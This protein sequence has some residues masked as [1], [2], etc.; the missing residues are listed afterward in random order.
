MDRQQQ[1]MGNEDGFVLVVALMVLAI[2][3]LIGIAGVATALIEQHIA[4]NERIR[5]TTF[6]QADGG[7]Q[8]AIRLVEEN[9]GSPGGFTA[10]TATVLNGS[11][12]TVLI[13]QANLATNE[14]GRTEAAFL[15][16]D[17]DVAFFPEGYDAAASDNGPHTNIIVD[18]VTSVATG[19]G[20]QMLAGYE[21]FGKGT[22]GGGGQI[23]YT[24]YAQHVGRA[25]SES[26]VQVTWRH[27]I[28]LELEGRY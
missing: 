21:G 25:K 24:I 17:R 23:L 19:S 4:R 18:G 20:L 26:V 15:S 7:T 22:A 14:H 11:D 12:N 9:L 27:A 1:R 16:G 6:Y 2:L 13:F 28:G 8:L 3:S 10:V 5:Q